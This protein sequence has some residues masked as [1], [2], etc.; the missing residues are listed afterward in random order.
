M[1]IFFSCLVASIVGYTM[2]RKPAVESTHSGSAA[3]PVRSSILNV[4]S[5]PGGAQVFVDSVF[6]GTT[7]V[8]IAIT[9]GIYEVRLNM[10]DYYEWEAQIQV[11]AEKPAPLNV[12]LVSIN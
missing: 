8:N 4:T 2:I 9:P 5:T 10:P 6:K 3:I 12:R 1:V 11:G 7:P